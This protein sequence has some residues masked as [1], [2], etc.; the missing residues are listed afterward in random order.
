MPSLDFQALMQEAKT[1]AKTKA[2]TRRKKSPTP[3]KIKTR[4]RRGESVSVNIGKQAD[5]YNAVTDKINVDETGSADMSWGIENYADKEKE[6]KVKYNQGLA[7][8][9]ELKKQKSN[10]S[11]EEYKAL[12]E[13]L[14]EKDIVI[15]NEKCKGAGPRI[16]GFRTHPN[17][18]KCRVCKHPSAFRSNDGGK[19]YH[20]RLSESGKRRK[21]KLIPKRPEKREKTVLGPKGWVNISNASDYKLKG[22]NGKII[23][24]IN[25]NAQTRQERY[26][27][28]INFNYKMNS[29]GELVTRT[30]KQRKNRRK[31][32]TKKDR[33]QSRSSSR[34]KRKS[35]RRISVSPY[36]KSQD[37][38][39]R[40]RKIKDINQYRKKLNMLLEKKRVQR[41]ANSKINCAI[42]KW[43]MGNNPHIIPENQAKL[44]KMTEKA[45]ILSQNYLD[46]L[47]D[48][49]VLKNASFKD[50]EDNV[51]AG[52]TPSIIKGGAK[53]TRRNRKRRNRTRKRY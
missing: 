44:L 40:V 5:G 52:K 39:T 1:R 3:Q 15:Q 7:E 51:P 25:L 21:K 6:W 8:Y 22:K 2:G 29:K 45:C 14:K 10:L 30:S 26:N 47:T 9:T 4:N 13:L 38:S 31:S 43:K 34:K 33:S 41:S 49:Q 27:Q 50:R 17:T 48:I 16:K 46:L 32:K 35:R 37:L 53:R 19:S 11:K 20:C 28:Y 12:K 24:K 18:K 36:K 42:R 23:K